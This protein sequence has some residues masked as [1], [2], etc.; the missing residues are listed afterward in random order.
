MKI[1]QSGEILFFGI[2]GIKQQVYWTSFNDFILL[3]ICY[4]KNAITMNLRFFKLCFHSVFY[5]KIK[6]YQF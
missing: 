1:P 5:K 6:F 2:L 4:C 3:N